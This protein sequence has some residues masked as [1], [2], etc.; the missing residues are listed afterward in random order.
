MRGRLF[1]IALL[2]LALIAF[3]FRSP[4]PLIYRQGEGFTYE[5][6]GE[7]K[8]KWQRESAREQL[9]VAQDAFDKKNYRLAMKA[10]KRTVKLR[11]LSDFAPQAQYLIGRCYEVQ[12]KDEKAFK[13]Y[14]EV[15][16]KYPKFTNYQDVQQRQFDIAVR[17]L[18]GQFYRLF[19]YVPLYRSW[20]KTAGLFDKVVKNGPYSPIAPQAQMDIGAAREKQGEFPLAV[21]AYE[22]AADRYAD[23]RQV[24]AD[25]TFK[26]GLAY[27]KEARTADYDQSVS[28]RAIA[29]FTDFMALYEDDPRVPDAQRRIASLKSEAA[30]GNFRIA[31]Y[32]EKGNKLEAA[33]IY[34][35]SAYA[36]DPTSSMGIQA[37][38]RIESLKARSGATPTST[39]PAK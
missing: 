25:A 7:E 17:F 19:G 16:E 35:N 15:L 12:H 24:A 21:K 2:L 34:Y 28:G 36:I 11:K 27:Q 5:W 1:R 32:Y 39:A 18:N 30:L 9:Q 3:P 29:T 23:Q 13:A 31:Q 38:R 6:P 22:R 20:D 14:Q 8:G 26:A 33:R 4:A 10:A 37:R